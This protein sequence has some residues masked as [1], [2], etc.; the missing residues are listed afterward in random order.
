MEYTAEQKAAIGARGKVIVSASAGS[1]KTFVMINRLVEL[2][3][4][5]GADVSKVLALTFTK[6]AAAQMRDRLRTALFKAIGEAADEDARRRLKEQLAA[7]PLA[8]IGTIHAFCGR[9][10]RTYFYL[11]EGLD[12]N[13]RIISSDDAEGNALSSRAVAEVF[14]GAYEEGGE[15]FLK[16]LSVFFRKKKD[17]RLKRTVLE[18]YGKVRGQEDYREVLRR[19]GREDKFDEACGILYGDAVERCGFLAEKAEGLALYLRVAKPR[20]ADVCNDIAAQCDK[21]RSAKDLFELSSRAREEFRIT[22]MP[23]KTNSSDLE[24]DYLTA[25]SKCSQ[26]IKDLCAEYGV[27]SSREEQFARYRDAQARAAAI[28]DLT[29]AYDDVFTRLKREANV[30]DY[31]DLEQFA[32]QVL[33]N[34]DVREELSQKYDYLFVDE[35]QDVNR[36]QDRIL[37]AVQGDA[38]DRDVFLVG[39]AKQAIY[40]FRGSS[41]RFFT[42]KERSFPLSLRLT[43]NF[44]SA[45]EILKAVNKVFR[46]LVKNYPEMRGGDRYGDYRGGVYFHFSRAREGTKEERKLS[47]YSVLEREGVSETDELAERVVALVEREVSER[48]PWYDADATYL[49]ENGEERKGVY[50]EVSFGDIAVLTRKNTGDAERIV[51]ALTRRGIPVTTSSKINV[52]DCF[53]V[54]VL[55]DWLS[56]L[57]NAEQDIPYAAALLSAVGGFGDGELVAIRTR[58]PSPYTFRDA[59]KEYRTKMA[60]EIASKLERFEET[61]QKLR[62]RAR[63]L[64]AAETIGLLLSMGI[65][66]QIAA[67]EGG[68]ERL[69]RV[70]RFTTEAEESGSVHDFL[71]RLKDS[72]YCV[73][74]AESGGNGAVKVLTMHASKGLEYPV[75]IL[76]GLDANYHGA[77]KDELMYTERLRVCPRSYDAEQKTV[78]DTVMRRAASV[79]QKREEREQEKNVLYVAMTRARCRL[80][81]MFEE[82]EPPLS[83]RYA[84]RF[85]DLFDFE[86]CKEYLVEDGAEEKAAAERKALVSERAGAEYEDAVRR[87]YGYK[88]KSEK[89]VALPVKSSATE[90]LRGLEFL[91]DGDEEGSGFTTEEGLAYHAFLERVNF[92]GNA[93]E[94]LARMRKEKLLP[95]ETL[96]LLDEEKLQRILDLPVL[97]NLAG[98]R[99]RR[100]QTF[101]VRLPSRELFEEGTEDE[102]VFQGA[103][104]LLAETENGYLI[105]DYKYSAHGDEYLRR[106]YAPQIKLYRKA[107]ARILRVDESKVAARIVNVARLRVIET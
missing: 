81:L 86:A 84:K 70:R 17:A 23:S 64:T 51:R 71:A 102:I 74:Y 33:Q 16:L 56:Y 53:E 4:K 65:E 15:D 36:I 72:E 20:A 57:D 90:L 44:R 28:A 106:R 105:L 76:A 11:F 34:G 5:D 14:D 46:P 55:I 7:L 54:R 98:K 107:V 88:Y 101:L 30:L 35:Y 82:K 91:P 6:K 69:A 50:K 9:L 60:D 94:E 48:V 85:S 79:L 10:V 93:A 43:S 24:L 66:A 89:S 49:D 19:V 68:Q 25:L 1:G 39:D 99:L 40:G 38:A 31:N 63:V 61:A 59:C 45:E 97:K 12:P 62:D 37:E 42:E 47:V 78:Y 32:L 22:R 21:L 13:F 26:A 95:E 83:A 2:I 73:E 27:Y 3:L 104:D 58:F 80:H 96:A 77:E 8:D 18:L 52:C 103:I 92:G 29:L 75:V 100:E 67:K 87:A 41:S